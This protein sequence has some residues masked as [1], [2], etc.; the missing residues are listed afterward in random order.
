MS[1]ERPDI[2]PLSSSFRML[3]DAQLAQ[4]HDASLE[5]LGQTGVRVHDSEARDL[6]GDAGCLISNGDLVKFPAAVVE[7][8]V[9]H[10][11]SRI[12]LHHRSGKSQIGLEGRTSYFGTGSDLMHTLDLETGERRLSRLSDVGDS[13]V[14]GPAL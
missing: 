6:L 7:E 2:S 8:A 4:I 12:V 14:D 1:E 9:D 11:P 13:D 10:A 3:S 5:I